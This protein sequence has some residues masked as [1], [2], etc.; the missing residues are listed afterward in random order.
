VSGF[1]WGS[2]SR[3]SARRT[4]SRRRAARVASR[5]LWPASRGH[6]SR[7]ATASLDP[8]LTSSIMDTLK[9]S[10][11][12][13]SRWSSASI[14]WRP[15]SPT[16]AHLGFR[17]GRVAFTV[18]RGRDRRRREIYGEDPRDEAG[19][20]RWGRPGVRAG[21]RLISATVTPRSCARSTAT[22]PRD[23]PGPVTFGAR[24]AC[25]AGS[26]PISGHP[27]SDVVSRIYGD[28]P[29]R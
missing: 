18:A 13:G 28:D 14:S 11:S 1:R 25:G 15:R 20:S 23:E 3:R 24:R 5:A 29:D 21:S 12:R 8:A 9:R 26:R 27:D 2:A 6:P 17:H 10:T 19:P 16:H 4:R 7:R 22:I